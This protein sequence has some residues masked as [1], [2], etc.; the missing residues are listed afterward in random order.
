MRR[1]A[2]LT[3]DRTFIRF[4][5]SRYSFRDIDRRASDFAAFLSR[6]NFPRQAKVAI[7]ARNCPD[8]IASYIGIL[9]AGGVAVPLNILLAPAEIAYILSDADAVLCFYGREKSDVVEEIGKTCSIEFTP[10]DEIREPAQRTVLAG[11]ENDSDEIATLLY[12]SGTTGHPKGAM[13]THR[14]IVSNAVAGTSALAVSERDR[15]IV[16]LPLS[17]SFTFTVCVVIPILLGASIT[18]LP[19]VKP[20]S[21]VIK[22]LVLDRVTVF[23]AVP[24]VYTL[25]SRKRLPFFFRYLLSLR[26]CISGAAPL[27][28]CTLEAFERAFRLPLLEGYGLTE[29]S[30]VVCVNRIAPRKPG[31]VG[32]PLPGVA[33]KVVDDEGV[34]VSIDTPGELLVKGPNVMKGYFKRADDT[35]MAIRGEWLCTGDI[36]VIDKEGYIKIVDRKKDM[37]IVDGLNVYPSEVEE[38]AL[39]HAAV[40]DCAMVG[41]TGEGER[42]LPVMFVTVQKDKA[43]NEKEL[44]SHLMKRIA[45]YKVPRRI[46]AVEELPRSATGKVLKRELK[47]WPLSL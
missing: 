31:T 25:L 8:F 21:N 10:F 1:R 34:E 16:F 24:I 42:E 18:L 29:A 45:P 5:G 15:L 19:S 11:I 3:P 7:L 46:I 12:T 26:F 41:I 30:P 32:L 14:N 2:E 39:T 20:F 36:A 28:L 6:R 35:A 27:P 17:H 44:R 23:V 33:V 43:L 47:K 40:S 37:I 38:A 22:R 13:L 4:E 9:R